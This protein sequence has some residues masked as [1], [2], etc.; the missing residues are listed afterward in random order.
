[1][2]T[3]TIL[4]AEDDC[5]IRQLLKI[6]IEHAGYKVI[7]AK[8][9]VEALE[10]IRNEAI[11]L[12]LLDIMM[13]RCNGFDVIKTLRGKSIYLPIIVL[14]AREEE[15]HKI[16]GLQLGADDYICKPFSYREVL[17]RINGQL[18]RYV[19][20]NNT[21]D[22]ESHTIIKNGP[23]EVDTSKFTATKKGIQLTLNPKEMKLLE[24]FI[25][26]LDRVFTK[27]QLYE[28][29]W[30][31]TYYGDDNT[32]MVHI[33]KLREKIEDNPKKPT[34]IQTIKGIGYRMVCYDKT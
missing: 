9:G 21:Y 1:M 6:H 2:D 7:E 23:I 17:G 25:H 15:D 8:D 32:I 10:W 31:D 19:H 4:I 27:K 33:S 30:E 12:L 26:H 20:Y 14:T 22:H 29:V 34:F 3:Q 11:H 16:L 28:M 13:P 18:R 5:D 24:V